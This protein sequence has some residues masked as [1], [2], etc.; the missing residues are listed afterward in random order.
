MSMDL[1]FVE[2]GKKCYRMSWLG[3]FQNFLV[4]NIRASDQN[5]Q[6]LLCV[7]KT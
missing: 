4:T 7:L 5:N 2:M 1:V 6:L 3:D